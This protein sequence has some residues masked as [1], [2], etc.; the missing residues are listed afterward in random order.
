MDS[1]A[2]TTARIL[3]LEARQD[4]ALRQLKAL[5]QRL[6][7]VLAEYSPA[8]NPAPSLAFSPGNLSM[9]AIKAA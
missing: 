4:E 1:L 2:D 8:V 5:E 9:P 6:E 3:D 7:Q